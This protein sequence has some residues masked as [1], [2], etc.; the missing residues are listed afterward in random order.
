MN[1]L[2]LTTLALLAGASL[3]I[4]A[5]HA[6]SVWDSIPNPDIHS[7]P[8]SAASTANSGQ[9]DQAISFVMLDSDGAVSHEALF[10]AVK[11]TALVQRNSAYVGTSRSANSWDN[12]PN[13]D[14]YVYPGDR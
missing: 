11:P 13:P 2:R 9:F 1:T 6:A 12:V 8:V 10:G 3:S 14:L 7:Y 4:N 5:A